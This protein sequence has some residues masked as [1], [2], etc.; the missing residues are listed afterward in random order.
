MITWKPPAAKAR[1]TG[2][3]DIPGLSQADCSLSLSLQTKVGFGPSPHPGA[4]GCEE[5]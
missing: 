5:A 4:Q 1:S 2:A 3:Q